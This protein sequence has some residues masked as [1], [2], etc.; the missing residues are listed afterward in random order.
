MTVTVGLGG[1]V[2]HELR[3]TAASLAIRSGANIKVVQTMMGHASA[4]MTWD[5]YGHLHDDDLDSV[6]E[7]LDVA[8]ADFLRNSCGLSADRGGVV[9]SLGSAERALTSHD[10]HER[11]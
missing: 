10:V 2:P 4:T 8:R 6:A 9:V 1:L 7:R 3:H 11:P 5:L